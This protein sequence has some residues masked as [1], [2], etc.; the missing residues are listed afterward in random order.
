M[1][2]WVRYRIPEKS[3]RYEPPLDC[4]KL[5]PGCLRSAGEVGEDVLTNVPLHTTLVAWLLRYPRACLPPLSCVQPL[6]GAGIGTKLG[7]RKI[8]RDSGAFGQE[9]G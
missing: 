8:A 4:R 2:V 5:Q 1:C 6:Q 7:A 3:P 9:K